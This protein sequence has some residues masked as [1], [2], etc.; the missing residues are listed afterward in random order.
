[1]SNLFLVVGESAESLDARA[2]RFA[3]VHHSDDGHIAD[4]NGLD[5]GHVIV[6]RVSLVETEVV[7]LLS[8]PCS[9]SAE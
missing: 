3:G 1:M 6:H 7:H 2:V 9:G 5:H 8:S 4:I